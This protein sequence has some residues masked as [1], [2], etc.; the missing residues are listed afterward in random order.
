MSQILIPHIA[1]EDPEAWRSG[2]TYMK[3]LPSQQ[4]TYNFKHGLFDVKSAPQSLF[5]IAFPIVNVSL[6]IIFCMVFWLFFFCIIRY[7]IL[8]VFSLLTNNITIMVT[9]E[10]ENF[11]FIVCL[12]ACLIVYLFIYYNRIYFTNRMIVIICT[13]WMYH[14][15]HMVHLLKMEMQLSFFKIICQ[16]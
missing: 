3:S 2:V 16:L 14:D 1:D 7:V 11:L 6:L 15:F 10:T 13:S 8:S 12:F 5:Y 9:K 4:K